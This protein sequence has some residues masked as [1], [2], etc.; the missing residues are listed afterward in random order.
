MYDYMF[1]H[2][3]FINSSSGKGFG[4]M[5]FI[6]NCQ[7]LER[8]KLQLSKK[9]TLEADSLGILFEGSTSG[10][11]INTYISCMCTL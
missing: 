11:S 4:R 3:D 10:T 6:R 1:H 9:N 5:I 7:P 2:G 8:L